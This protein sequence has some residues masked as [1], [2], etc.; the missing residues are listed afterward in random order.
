MKKVI[1]LI[2]SL[3]TVILFVGCGNNIGVS[4]PN[5]WTHNKISAD[6]NGHLYATFIPTSDT[7]ANTP[8]TVT[9]H[10]G[11][12]LIGSQSLHWT[13]AEIK[14]FKS[15]RWYDRFVNTTIQNDPFYISSKVVYYKL[16]ENQGAYLNLPDNNLQ[17]IFTVEIRG[18]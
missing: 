6:D 14:A 4:I 9:W 3:M 12:N 5:F 11:S 17:R 2:L 18:D 7:V 13:D 16:S 1:C 8:Y 10:E 15:K